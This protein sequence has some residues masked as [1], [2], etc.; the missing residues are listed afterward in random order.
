[1]TDIYGD[2]M[3]NLENLIYRAIPNLF[4]KQFYILFSPYEH[5]QQFKYFATKWYMLMVFLFL[6]FFPFLCAHSHRKYFIYE[7]LD[8]QTIFYAFFFF[9]FIWFY[10]NFIRILNSCV[11]VGIF[12]YGVVDM[13]INKRGLANAAVGVV[14]LF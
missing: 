12:I 10:A 13:P 7:K 2:A 1:M 8:K 14:A 3:R 6:K 9:Y 5:I 11:I 4:L